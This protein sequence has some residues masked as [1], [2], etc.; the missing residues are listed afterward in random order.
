MYVIE[1]GKWNFRQWGNQSVE[2]VDEFWKYYEQL[3][4]RG[5]KDAGM[6]H[7]AGVVHLVDFEGFA[8]SH[9]ASPKGE[10]LQARV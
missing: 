9:H 8:L 5:E 4:R 3:I 2:K 1:F 7:D 10:S 6:N